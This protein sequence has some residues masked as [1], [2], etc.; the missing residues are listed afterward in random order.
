MNKL[1]IL[2]IILIL[3]CVSLFVYCY[4]CEKNLTREINDEI[5]KDEKYK[6]IR[7]FSEQSG[8]VRNNYY[9]LTN[10]DNDDLVRSNRYPLDQRKY[11]LDR[12]R[13]INRIE[14]RQNAIMPK[15]TEDGIPVKPYGYYNEIPDINQYVHSFDYNTGHK[16]LDGFDIYNTRAMN[17]ID[18]KDLNVINVN[19]FYEPY[20]F[21][22]KPVVN[23][24]VYPLKDSQIEIKNGMITSSY[25]NICSRYGSSYLPDDINMYFRSTW[26]NVG[27]LINNGAQPSFNVLNLYAQFRGGSLPWVYRVYNKLTSSYIFLAD[28]TKGSGTYGALRDGDIISNVPAFPGNYTVQIQKDRSYVFEGN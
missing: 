20:N 24:S 12:T 26:C 18:L 11:H 7:K 3:I 23:S 6:E 2:I 25:P 4:L 28:G 19:D 1:V 13:G 27:V 22:Y 10:S 21:R 16:S 9:V 5:H 15:L 17:D 14:R 8:P